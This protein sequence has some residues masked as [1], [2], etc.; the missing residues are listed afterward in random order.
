[1]RLGGDGHHSLQRLD[2]KQEALDR[3]KDLIARNPKNYDAIVTLGS[4]DIVVGEIDR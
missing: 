4:T 2:R 3:L 1:M